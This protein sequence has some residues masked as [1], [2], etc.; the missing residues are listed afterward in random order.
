MMLTC[1]VSWFYL[2]CRLH[3]SIDLPTWW[4]F[5]FYDIIWAA[6]THSK[7]YRPKISNARGEHTFCVTDRTKNNNQAT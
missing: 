3:N 5:A 6:Q 1:F 7:P 4:T 2:H